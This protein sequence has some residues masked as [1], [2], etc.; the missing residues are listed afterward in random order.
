MQNLLGFLNQN[1]WV[2]NLNIGNVMQITAIQLHEFLIEPLPEYELTRS[3]FLEKIS[4]LVVAYFCMSTETR[5]I[6]TKSLHLEKEIVEA[7]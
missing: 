2:Y 7:M 4:L 1:E 5:F 3:S 6:L